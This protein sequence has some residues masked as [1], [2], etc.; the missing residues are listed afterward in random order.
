MLL[1]IVVCSWVME[2]KSPSAAAE[3][4]NKVEP[5]TLVLDN[6]FLYLG[7]KADAGN[8]TFLSDKGIKGIVNVAEKDGFSNVNSDKEMDYLGISCFDSDVP[9]ADHSDISVSL[10]PSLRVVRGSELFPR[11]QRHFGDAIAFIN[12]HVKEEKPVLVHCW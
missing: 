5:A 10:C 6:G 8:S 3:K 9:G 1:G 2:T 11:L 4:E 12:E 7:S